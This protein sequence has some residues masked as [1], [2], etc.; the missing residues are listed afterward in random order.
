MDPLH[1]II[2]TLFLF[3][4]TFF[5]PGANL[6]IVVQTTLSS[7]KKAGLTCG[8]GV[9]LGNAIY[10]G[11]GLFGLVTLMSEFGSLFSLIKIL[12]G[13]YLF[14]Y[15]ITVFKNRTQ[16]NL[17]TENIVESFPS[18]VYFRRGVISDL[19]NP[20]T[21]LFFMSIFS[22]TIS[23]STPLWTKL[24]IW[25]GIIIASLIWRIILC[26][27]FSMTSVRRMYSRIH[28]IVGKAVGIVLGTLASRL[29]Y[30]GVTELVAKR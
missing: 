27:T 25:F 28:K 16:L 12:G 24:V 11:L 1:S 26:Q 21:V 14:Y 5:N 8:Y 4:L 9:V 15:A 19:S 10:S 23:P 2:I 29:I 20:Q 13:L 3:V 7:G 6:F 17:S 22:T 18:G 30:Q